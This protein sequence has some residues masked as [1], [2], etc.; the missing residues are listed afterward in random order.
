MVLGAR[1]SGKSKMISVITESISSSFKRVILFLGTYNCNPWLV[2][3]VTKKFDD[4]LIFK[5]FQENIIKKILEQQEEHLVPTL[6]IFDDAF[7]ST[8]YND[9]LSDLFLTGRHY[10]VSCIVIGISFA[11]LHKNIRRSLDQ[12]LLFKSVC[13]N[14]NKILLEEYVTRYNRDRA[15]T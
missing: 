10:N 5:Q 9:T 8:K 13:S 6:I 3:F 11:L 14:D 12:I 15:T 7:R 4:R 1:R 2:D